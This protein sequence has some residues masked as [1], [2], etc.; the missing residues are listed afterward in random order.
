MR[1]AFFSAAY[2]H[3]EP[4]TLRI[5][6][7]RCGVLPRTRFASSGVS[8]L[9][10]SGCSCAATAAGG[11]KTAMPLKLI[12]ATIATRGRYRRRPIIRRS[13]FRAHAHDLDLEGAARSLVP[14][15][16]PRAVAEQGLAERRAGREHV[17]GLV[18]LL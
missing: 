9:H 2:M 7:S 10:A 14:H 3:S 6:A 16:P 17:V 4:W 8:T 15:D 5:F 13:H 11:V 12:A 18:G 1:F